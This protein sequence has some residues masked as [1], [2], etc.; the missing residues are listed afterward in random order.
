MMKAKA[1]LLTTC[2][3]MIICMGM[4]KAPAVEM[5]ETNGVQLKWVRESLEKHLLS[6]ETVKNEVKITSDG[7]YRKPG[8]SSLSFF[9][10]RGEKLESSD[11]HSRVSAVYVGTAGK[12]VRFSYEVRFD[13]RS[14][15]K[16]QISVDRGEV[17]LE[18]RTASTPKP[19]PSK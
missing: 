16:D 13:S 18:T 17:T 10:K 1:C 12:S 5:K 15:G 19:P 2:L 9:L 11:H 4:E 6:I 8:E 3:F 7:Q 14:F